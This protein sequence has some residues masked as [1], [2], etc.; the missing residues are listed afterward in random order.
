MQQPTPKSVSYETTM[1]GLLHMHQLAITGHSESDEADRVRES[2]S[3]IWDDLTKGEKARF[4]GLSKDLYAISDGHES[5]PERITQKQAEKKLFEAFEARTRCDWDKS[6]EL[7]RMCAEHVSPARLSYFRGRVWQEGGEHKVAEVFFENATK[8]EP[9]NDDYQSGRL[10]NLKGANPER[11]VEFAE[12][13]LQA[14]TG[15]SPVLVLNAAEIAFEDIQNRSEINDSEYMRLI[16]I[17]RETLTRIE[18][19]IDLLQAFGGMALSL[20]AMCYRCIGD[21]RSAIA[22]YT[23]AIPLNP[24]SDSLLVARGILTYGAD[25]SAIADFVQAIKL[26]S[27]RI[28]PYYFLAHHYLVTN[29]FDECL[30][31]CE[32]AFSKPAP[33]RVQSDLWSFRAVCSAVLGYP[34]RVVRRAFENSI[35]IDPSNE[36]AHHN[37]LSF[38]N[39]LATRNTRYN[40][41][42]LS[43][44]SIQK[45]YD[46]RMNERPSPVA[47]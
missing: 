15:K 1:R 3:D 24:W 26:G 17:L 31:M 34:E 20:L 43:V 35:R 5:P 18:G 30:E 27:P 14:S 44:S 23:R 47:V 19:K 28:W 38:E 40:F 7:L 39:G 33:S 36:Q 11:A 6:L 12:A 9:E 45:R 25:P 46:T 22:Y 10:Y 21:T 16:Q 29:R 32:Q 13:V 8:L 4:T 2:M 37:L 42:H 41:E